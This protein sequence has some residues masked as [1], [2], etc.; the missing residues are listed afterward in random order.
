MASM[1]PPEQRVQPDG[2]RHADHGDQVGLVPDLAMQCIVALCPKDLQIAHIGFVDRSRP[3]VVAGNLI[4]VRQ[5]EDGRHVV[6][7]RAQ[8]CVA[9]VGVPISVVAVQLADEPEQLPKVPLCRTVLRLQLLDQRFLDVDGSGDLRGGSGRGRWSVG[10]PARHNSVV[11]P[12]PGKGTVDELETAI[13]RLRGHQF[14]HSLDVRLDAGN[15]P[16]PEDLSVQIPAP[17]PI[18][19]RRTGPT[20]GGGFVV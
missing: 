13:V 11:T 12:H 9:C 16:V 15:V 2:W 10:V 3:L 4:E 20:P 5:F 17:R 19:R 8:Q 1:Q 7:D 14:H 6:R 18:G